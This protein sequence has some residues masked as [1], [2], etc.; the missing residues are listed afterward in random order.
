M[1]AIIHA[2][3]KSLNEKGRPVALADIL[4]ESP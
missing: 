4:N 3:V 1:T 2:G